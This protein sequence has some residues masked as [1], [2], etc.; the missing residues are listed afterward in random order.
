MAGLFKW[1]SD[2]WTKQFPK[3][4]F[5]NDAAEVA[6]ALENAEM[7]MPSLVEEEAGTKLFIGAIYSACN[8]PVIFKEKITTVITCTNDTRGFPSFN[9]N[10]KRLKNNLGVLFATLTWK[11][12][13]EQILSKDDLGGAIKFIHKQRQGGESVLVHCVMGKSR[14]A[15]LVL[16]YMMAKEGIGLDEALEKL[17]ACR[18]VAPRESFLRQLKELEDWLKSLKSE[19]KELKEVVAEEGVNVAV[20]GLERMK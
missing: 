6:I 1:V 7:A 8:Q 13:D 15:A 4:L 5:V 12:D 18:D 17:K 20:A 10:V 2:S 9:N 3:G 11:D 14:S 16:G 19:M